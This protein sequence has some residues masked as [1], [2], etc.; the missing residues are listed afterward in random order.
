MH[1]MPCSRCG[2]RALGGIKAGASNGIGCVSISSGLSES[3]AMEL[4]GKEGFD[5]EGEEGF[6]IEARPYI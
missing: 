3:N 4:K 5:I 6:D 2:V 1:R